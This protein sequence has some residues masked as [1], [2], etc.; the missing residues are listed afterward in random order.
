MQGN[1]IGDSV[2]TDGKDTVNGR[3]LDR[4]DSKTTMSTAMLGADLNVEINTST[5]SGPEDSPADPD[6]LRD[7]ERRAD[8]DNRGAV[9]R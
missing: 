9:W 2:Y 3:E 1:R 5:W 7:Q 4:S 8:S 6:A